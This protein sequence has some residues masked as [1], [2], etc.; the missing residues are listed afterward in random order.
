MNM[1]KLVSGCCFRMLLL[2][3]IRVVTFV[4][5]LDDGAG[6]FERLQANHREFSADTRQ[7]S[8]RLQSA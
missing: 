8:L 7:E 2:L 1:T 6:H 5:V 4:V 3:I